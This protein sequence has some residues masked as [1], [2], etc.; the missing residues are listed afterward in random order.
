MRNVPLEIVLGNRSGDHIRFDVLGLTCRN[1]KTDWDRTHLNTEIHVHVD[2]FRGYRSLAMLSDD[3]HRF[4]SGLEM[5][6]SGGSNVSVLE[7]GD[8]LSVDVTTAGES[9]KVWM[10]LDALEDDG[11]FILR[12]GGDENWEW[13]VAM[14]R[15]E[16]QG[17]I[18]AAT[19]VS[20]RYP[21]WAIPPTGPK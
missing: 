13:H 18:N 16:L 15:S 4:R 11:E 21:M 10:Q 5:I 2:S 6:D 7:T 8:F 12:D 19:K 3:F 17:L 1:P 20:E 14:E 9:L